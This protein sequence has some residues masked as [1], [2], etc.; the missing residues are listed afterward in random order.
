MSIKEL[1][2]KGERIACEYLVKKGYKIL[3]RNC[4]LFCGE[5]D[6]ICRKKGVL[7]GDKTI[8]FVEVKTL[9]VE[10]NFYPEE[11]V[12]FRKKRKLRQLAEI[13]LQKHKY[14]ENTPYQIDIVAVFAD[15]EPSQIEYFENVVEDK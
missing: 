11:H 7:A 8:H 5:I 4:V 10:N 15:S 14:P 9:F 6:I 12:D 2:D 13:W 3:E 1:G